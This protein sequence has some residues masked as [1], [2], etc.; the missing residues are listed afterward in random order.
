MPGRDAAERFYEAYLLPCVHEDLQRLADMVHLV[1]DFP[2]PSDQFRHV[3]GSQHLGGLGLCTAL[4][5]THFFGDWA[6]VN[7]VAC[8]ESGGRV[9]ASALSARVSIPLALIREGGKLPPPTLF[10]VKSPSYVS[11]PMPKGSQEKKD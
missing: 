5:Q 4:L 7:T 1:S 10:V 11:F 8:C 2:R 3:W 6:K 9:Y